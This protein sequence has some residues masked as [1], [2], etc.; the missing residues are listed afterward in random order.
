MIALLGIAACTFLTFFP[1]LKNGFV[2]WDD[3]AYV[4]DNLNIRLAGWP[5]FHWSFTA[6]ING[7]WHPLTLL[8]YALDYA[9]WGLNPF[10]FHLTGI[11]LHTLNVC[12][13]FSL[14]RR[15][16]EAD[17]PS[18][19]SPAFKQRALII[20]G[21]TALLFS[22]H[23]LRVESVVWISE[24]KDVLS[25]FFFLL[26]V[27][28]YLSYVLGDS[29]KRHV[30]YWISVLL[31]VPAILSKPMAVSLPF[32]LL[33][34]DY[35]PLKRMGAKI[36]EKTPFFLLSLAGIGTTLWAQHGSAALASMESVPAAF[37]IG[38][39]VRGLVFYLGKM[40]LPIN[41]VP[42]YPMPLRTELFGPIFYASLALL[43]AIS[44]LCVLLA[45]K[46]KMFLAAW[47]YYVITLLPVI[48][49]VQSGSQFAADRYTY[50][51]GLGPLVLVGAGS[52]YLYARFLRYW[53]KAVLVA[54]AAVAISLLA[55]KTIRQTAV[56]KD[57]L[58]LWSHE[59]RLYPGRIAE[60][61]N[62]LGAAYAGLGRMEDAAKE[63]SVAIRLRPD[64]AAAAHNNLGAAYHA[65]G[66]NEEAVRETATAIR[67]NPGDPDAH[68]N[69]GMMSAQLGR[70]EAAVEEFSIVVKLRPD[71]RSAHENMGF[72]YIRL[73]RPPDAA[74]AFEAVLRLAP[75]SPEAHNNLGG[76]YM[77]SGRVDDAIREFEAALK[78]RPDNMHARSNLEIALEARQRRAGK[79]R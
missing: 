78:L 68:Y 39:P 70:F 7:H 56:W 40:L 73:G 14:I 50:L 48:G 41:L 5:L 6:G 11:I 74:R 19:R 13:V 53:Q 54:I 15:L 65:L 60:A 47:L 32:V 66:R 52:G 28:A 16:A 18:D 17:A 26:S 72:A 61:H 29:A 22:V 46:N 64:R 4:Y 27:R 37:R 30:R 1:A 51:P 55:A 69:L 2:N 59:V 45:R 31:F 9:C 3:N 20:A 34:L 25:A 57:S 8:S 79:R 38:V 23:P 24:R 21:V 58:T 71:E 36:V 44:I 33:V 49:I 43:S 62:Y 42:L 76:A 35:Y 12:L 75:D 10:G 77:Q 67:L 63:Y